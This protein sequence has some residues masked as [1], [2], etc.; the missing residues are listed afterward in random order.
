MSL[1][2]LYSSKT[3]P[4]AHVLA[5]LIKHLKLDVEIVNAKESA[6]F[7]EHFPLKKIPAFIDAKGFK[8][9]ELPAI[10]FYRMF[11]SIFDFIPSFRIIQS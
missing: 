1:G 2:T 8:L 10:A 4:S 9:T 7:A 6:Q 3:S 11:N 5:G